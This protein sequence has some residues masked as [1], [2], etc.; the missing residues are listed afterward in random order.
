MLTCLTFLAA[1]EIS[2]NAQLMFSPNLQC[3]SRNIYNVFNKVF[4]VLNCLRSDVI[5]D[6]LISH[7]PEEFENS[8]VV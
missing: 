3:K 4:I 1:D 8:T 5:Q 2:I 6:L 7:S